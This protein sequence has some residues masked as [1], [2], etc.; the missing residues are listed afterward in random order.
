MTLRTKGPTAA[1]KVRHRIERQLIARKMSAM[2][3]TTPKTPT[4]VSSDVIV[5]S[6]TNEST[7]PPPTRLLSRLAA[8]VPRATLVDVKRFSHWKLSAAMSKRAKNEL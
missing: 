5:E 4:P 8:F 7:T 1:R 3:P 2:K 6:A